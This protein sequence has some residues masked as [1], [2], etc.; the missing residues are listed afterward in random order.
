V[1]L[2]DE[3]QALLR[4]AFQTRNRL[5][6][7]VSGTGSA[8]MESAIVN[9]VEPGD[10]VLI[11]IKGYFGARMGEMAERDGAT[12]SK[13]EGPLGEALERDE[14]GAAVK[15]VG[16][17]IVGIVHAET[18]TGVLQPLEEI[19]RIVHEAGALIVIDTVTSLGCVP[20]EID[21]WEIDAAYSASQKG[22]SC[23]PG[24]APITSGPKAVEVITKRQTKA[25]DWYIATCTLK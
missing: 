20:V 23:P 8:G 19:A 6:M 14:V 3:T 18:S 10:K 17:K 11:C 7:A 5:T 9:L 22:L 16:P 24:L 21:A 25:R 12:G 4:Y 1:A 2:M 15:R 13:I